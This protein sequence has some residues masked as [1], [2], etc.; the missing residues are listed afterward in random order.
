MLADNPETNSYVGALRP[1][2]H[3]PATFRNEL[4]EFIVDQ[5]PRWRDRTDRPRVTSETSLTS[6][7]CAH[8]NSAARNSAGWDVLQFRVEEPDEK[9]KGRKIDLIPAPSG[10]AICIEGRRHTD[11][12]SI[13]PIECKRFP[14]PKDKDRDE[15]EYVIS[16]YSSIG[17]IQRFKACHHGANHDLAAMIG[18]VQEKTTIFWDG[19][20]SEWIGNLV[21]TNALGWTAKDLLHPTST[22]SKLRVAM[23]QSI[24]ERDNSLPDIQLRHIWIEMN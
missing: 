2:V 7:L 5:L 24:H 12:E 15:R 22:D 8:L 11:F 17:G 6:Q 18:Y 4:F 9:Y 14:T 20:V 19:R 16:R 13:M 23:F 1:D 21:K 3:K 10:A